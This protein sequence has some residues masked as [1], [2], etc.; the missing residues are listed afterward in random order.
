MPTFF[1]QIA[2]QARE[3]HWQTL[4]KLGWYGKGMVVDLT[5]L[6]EAALKKFAQWQSEAVD[7][8]NAEYERANNR[9]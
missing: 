8:E 9:G 7:K 5:K 6:P 2:Y 4:F 3:D 1:V